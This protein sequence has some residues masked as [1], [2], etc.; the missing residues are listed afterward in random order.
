MNGRS[1]TGDVTV[2]GSGDEVTLTDV[3]GSASVH[4]DFFS[5][6]HAQRIGGAF[7]YHSSRSDVSLARLNG[8]LQIDGNDLTA[9]EA[10]GPMRISTRSRNITLE[11]VTGDISIT[12]NH[13]DVDVHVA[14][15]T[16]NITVDNQNGNVNITLPEKSRFTL[17]AETSD[18]DTHS[19]FQGSD[20]HGG[21]GM[22]SGTFNG[23]GVAVKLNTSHGDINVNRNSIAPLPPAPP[24]LHLSVPAPPTPSADFTTETAAEAVA[25][26]KKQAQ[27]AMREA[28]VEM[29]EAQ[30]KRD[31]AM[32]MARE[33]E[34]RAKAKQQ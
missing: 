26:A 9:N 21:H 2:D 16:G 1:I 28:D 31:E 4:G 6:G 29:K 7:N 18:G 11:K 19:D 3:S 33:A 14:P 12:N 17:N 25:D 13:G 20:T 34:A 15:P 24:T 5:G 22:L 8:D 27:E 23:G 10:I 32:K 30:R